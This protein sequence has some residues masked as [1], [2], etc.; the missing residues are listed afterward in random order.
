LVSDTRDLLPVA[1]KSGTLIGQLD[2]KTA[3]DVLLGSQ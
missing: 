3:L 1:D 2:R